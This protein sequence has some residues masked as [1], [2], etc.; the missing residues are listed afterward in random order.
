MRALP[1]RRARAMV[2]LLFAAVLV[3][4]GTCMGVIG[5][6]QAALADA[7]PP[8]PRDISEP[9]ALAKYNAAVAEWERTYGPA[10]LARRR[11]FTVTL[12][13]AY[14]SMATCAA[15]LSGDLR[16][17]SLPPPRLR[18]PSPGASPVTFRAAHV[19]QLPPGSVSCNFTAPSQ[20]VLSLDFSHVAPLP[21]GKG[22]GLDP[23]T[24]IALPSD[25]AQ[26][27]G[28]LLALELAEVCLVVDDDGRHAGGCV[29]FCDA[30]PVPAGAPFSSLVS[31]PGG[32]VTL[33]RRGSG[34]FRYALRPALPAVGGTFQLQ[35]LVQIRSLRDP[36]VVLQRMNRYVCELPRAARPPVRAPAQLVVAW[37]CLF[38]TAG[39]LGIWVAARGVDG[40][41]EAPAA[42]VQGRCGDAGAGAELSGVAGG[43]H[44][45][46]A[47][48][49]DA[50][51]PLWPEGNDGTGGAAMVT[52]M[53]TVASPLYEGTG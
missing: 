40:P 30:A 47:Q 21:G 7:L 9:V 24:W 28:E 45:G 16:P 34:L 33:R 25:A 5:V 15:A 3:A 46:E 27:D 32:D 18:S 20:S 41:D 29:S 51:P 39:V 49:P 4:L 36:A 14:P 35:P 31:S 10:F 11:N 23:M 12:T 8:P 48:A 43:C 22:L 50:P 53:V 44:G 26:N 1:G 19:L 38:V 6:A 42:A 13:S 52:A 17:T 37:G 2:A